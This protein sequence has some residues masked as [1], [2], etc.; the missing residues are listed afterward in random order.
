MEIKLMKETQQ[1]IEFNQVKKAFAV[2]AKDYEIVNHPHT[3]I[4]TPFETPNDLDE[5]GERQYNL[6]L[7]PENITEK[8]FLEKLAGVL[9]ISCMD[10]DAAKPLYDLVQKENPKTPLVF[11]SMA[12]GIIQEH[13]QRKDALKTILG[14]IGL[15]QDKIDKVIA[16]DHDHTC[17]YIKYT[18]GGTP[19]ANI[20]GVEPATPGNYSSEK[21]QKVMKSLIAQNA[22]ENH[23]QE[24]FGEKLVLGLAVID[25]KGNLQLDT[26]FNEV[27]PQSL[28]EIRS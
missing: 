11:L 8:E 14:Y 26:N 21:E 3:P 23:L 18:L 25:R 12:G 16:T 7:L 13:P 27:V 17:G 2:F 28:A 22:K 15:H 19:L 10:R 6:T 5:K 24:L 20:I 9:V 4:R 1:S